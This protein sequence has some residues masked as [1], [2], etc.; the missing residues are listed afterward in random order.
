[1]TCSDIGQIGLDSRAQ[2]TVTAQP[3]ILDAG[4]A[5]ELALVV[6]ESAVV[7]H[8]EIRHGNLARAVDF[9]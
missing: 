4:M 1:M 9:N 2:G 8:R 6:A 7:R 5:P 3:V